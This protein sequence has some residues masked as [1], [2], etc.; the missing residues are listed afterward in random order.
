MLHDRNIKFGQVMGFPLGWAETGISLIQTGL[1][2]V[3]IRIIA[4]RAVVEL[5]ND[6]LIA[7]VTVILWVHFDE[8]VLSSAV[9]SL[10]LG[11]TVS[12]DIVVASVAFLAVSVWATDDLI[13]DVAFQSN[14]HVGIFAEVSKIRGVATMA[15]FGLP[16]I[17]TD[18]VSRKEPTRC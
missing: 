2:D 6:A 15:F 11:Q 7:D 13:A 9:T 12:T 3:P 17:Y 10:T 14:F 1:A 18:D 8:V 4:P 16:S 5:P